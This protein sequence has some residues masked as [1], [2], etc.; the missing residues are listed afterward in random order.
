MRSISY[1]GERGLHVTFEQPIE[2]AQKWARQ[3]ALSPNPLIRPV[4]VRSHGLVEVDDGLFHGLNSVTADP[5]IDRVHQGGGGE[6]QRREARKALFALLEVDLM[7]SAH[8][9]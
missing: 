7:D 8:A 4:R 3:R 9:R 2:D 1:R 6:A 5:V